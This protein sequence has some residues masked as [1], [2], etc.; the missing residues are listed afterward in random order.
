M[1]NKLLSLLLVLPLS[2][3]V[4]MAD[5]QVDR[6][7]IDDLRDSDGDGV[8]NQRDLCDNT[9]I[10][11]KVDVKGCAQWHNSNA[12]E[13]VVFEFEYDQAQL[14]AKDQEK[15][16]QLVNVLK[17]SPETQLILIGDTSS[18]GSLEYN[19]AL[20]ER[21]NQTVKAALIAQGIAAS[22]IETQVFSDDTQ[23]THFLKKR[24]RRTFAVF[25]RGGFQVDQAWTIFSSEQQSQ[26][27]KG[28]N[29]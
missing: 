23:L 24:Q 27:N 10:T 26:Y 17:Q 18:E 19:N 20:A 6:F 3:C 21:R 9:A 15:I 8:I 14:Q 1:K 5:P 11:T 2:A 16:K 28:R 13:R 12:V 22:R 7:Q 29:Q 25:S 4:Q